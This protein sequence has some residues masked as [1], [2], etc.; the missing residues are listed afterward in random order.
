MLASSE[1]FSPFYPNIYP[2]TYPL[3]GQMTNGCYY[4]DTEAQSMCRPR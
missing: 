1:Y 2:N 3:N 4:L